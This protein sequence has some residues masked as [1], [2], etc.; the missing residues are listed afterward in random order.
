[1]RELWTASDPEYD[2]DLGFLAGSA[3]APSFMG[4]WWAFWLLANLTGWIT[5]NINDPQSF[6][7]ALM[8]SSTFEIIAAF[9]LIK[10]VLDI[11]KRQDLRSRRIGTMQQS[12]PPPPPTFQV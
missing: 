5:G 7:I 11:G 8:I 12:V 6:P 9:L 3:T 2:A 4:F 1:M 10:L